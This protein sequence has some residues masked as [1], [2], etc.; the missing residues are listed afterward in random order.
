MFEHEGYEVYSM[1]TKLK[2]LLDSGNTFR[3]RNIG[4]KYFRKMDI[5]IL[6]YT[7]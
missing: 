2:Y 1:E 3:F 7:A 5:C 4:I 6:K